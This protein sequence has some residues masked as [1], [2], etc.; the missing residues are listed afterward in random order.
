MTPTLIETD[1]SNPDVFKSYNEH[2]NTII[3]E[4]DSEEGWTQF[5]TAC[6]DLRDRP[7]VVN[8]GARNQ[9]SISTWGETISAL[10]IPHK[11]F[12]VINNEL[13][14]VILLNEYAKTVPVE[15]VTVVKNGFYG[16]E[17]VFIPFENSKIRQQV[18]NQ[19]YL[20]KMLLKAANEFYSKRRPLHLIAEALPFGERILFESWYNKTR[21]LISGAF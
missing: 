1:T 21:A 4:I 19:L 17:E 13:D 7:I 11:T 9:N 10:Q 3:C 6:N 16:K 18:T 2:C 14:S 15:T 8:C 5:L 20:P 12:W